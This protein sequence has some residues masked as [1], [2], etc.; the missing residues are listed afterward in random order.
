MKSGSIAAV[1]LVIFGGVAVIAQDEPDK[2]EMQDKYALQIPD[3]LAFAEFEGYESWPVVSLSH[4][5]DTLNVI[6]ANS[7][8]IDAYAAGH[9]GN[10]K[11]W[12]DGAKA[13]KIQYI[14]KKNADAPF[15][16]SVP[17]VLKD[18]AFMAKDSKRFASSGGW[19]YGMFNYDRAS[20]SFTPDGM[21][22]SCGA[23]C[24]SIVKDRD[25]V[26]TEWGKR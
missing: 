21:G 23:K 4:S 18:V 12:P 13:A 22:F 10:G 11:P 20:D 7:V 6:V 8:M 1:A 25:F 2:P 14:P 3:G 26:F 19:G 9:P 5:P 17:D 16:V 15:D 24:H